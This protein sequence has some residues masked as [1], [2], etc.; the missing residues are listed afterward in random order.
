MIQTRFDGTAIHATLDEFGSISPVPQFHLPAA[1]AMTPVPTLPYVLA[2]VQDCSD[3]SSGISRHRC[4]CTEMRMEMALRVA[5]GLLAPFAPREQLPFLDGPI[6]ADHLSLDRS[7]VHSSPF[8][9]I[10]SKTLEQ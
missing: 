3:G 4:F 7:L 1:F 2:A 9:P 5:E 8:P 10:I 6:M